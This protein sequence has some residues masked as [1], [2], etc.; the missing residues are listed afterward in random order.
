M[1]KDLGTE[2]D[3]LLQVHDEIVFQFPADRPELAL[4]ARE[5][6]IET[7]LI[8][9]REMTIPSDLKVG[10]SWGRMQAV[11]EETIVDVVKELSS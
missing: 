11:T 6:M 5:R 1:Y 7:I 4:Q 9:G 2:I 8:R 10:K 3:L